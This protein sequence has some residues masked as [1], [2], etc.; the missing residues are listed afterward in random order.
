MYASNM[1]DQGLG[2][3]LILDL[4]KYREELGVDVNSMNNNPFKQSPLHRVAINKNWHDY[5]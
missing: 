5:I 2:G 1:D 4:L 3:R